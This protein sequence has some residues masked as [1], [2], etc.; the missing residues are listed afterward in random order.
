MTP[1]QHRQLW[2]LGGLVVVLDLVL[3][4][5]FGFSFLLFALALTPLAYGIWLAIKWSSAWERRHE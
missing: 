3:V 1:K 2:V 5:T 4:F